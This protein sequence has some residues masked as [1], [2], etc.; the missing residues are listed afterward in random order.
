[1]TMEFRDEA[2]QVPAIGQYLIIDW[3]AASRHR[4]SFD[5]EDRGTNF[6]LKSLRKSSAC[7]HRLQL[8]VGFDQGDRVSLFEKRE[9]RLNGQIVAHDLPSDM[10]RQICLIEGNWYAI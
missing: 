8:I 3:P 1:M 9:D 10:K 7:S 5:L 6:Y 4:S 2:N